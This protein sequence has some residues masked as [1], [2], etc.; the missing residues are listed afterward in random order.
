MLKKT[1]PIACHCSLCD[2]PFERLRNRGSM[3]ECSPCQSNRRV[4]GWK[5]ANPERTKETNTQPSAESKKRYATSERGMQ[6]S[7][8]SANRFYRKDIDASRARSRALYA[9]KLDRPVRV[10]AGG[11]RTCSRST[12]KPTRSWAAGTTKPSALARGAHGSS[13]SGP[14]SC[15]WSST[16]CSSGS[17][18]AWTTASGTTT[19]KLRGP[20]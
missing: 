15:G 6:V 4:L 11:V 8:D 9:A 13:R 17:R 12:V 7:R 3:T 19:P 20:N 5:R 2:K 18:G 1:G 10:P 14:Q 16:H